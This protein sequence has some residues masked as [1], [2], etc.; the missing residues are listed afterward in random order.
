VGYVN[1]FVQLTGNHVGTPSG[2]DPRYPEA[3]DF[4]P[5]ARMG[6]FVMLRPRMLV[7]EAAVAGAQLGDGLGVADARDRVGEPRK[8]RLSGRSE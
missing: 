2:S 3:I 4:W 7:Y 8:A 5:W 1:A 6:T